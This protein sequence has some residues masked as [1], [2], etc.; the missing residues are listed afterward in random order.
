MRSGIFVSGT[1][2]DVGKS[3]VSAM[4]LYMLRENGINACYFK[5]ALSG[6]LREGDMLIPGDG[7]FVL[8][9][10][11]VKEKYDRIIPHIYEIPVSPHLAGRIE[12]NRVSR[13]EIIRKYNELKEAYDYIL[14]EGA[15]GL[16]VPLNDQG[17]M[18]RDLI[19]DLELDVILVSRAGVGT[20]NHTSL[21]MEYAKDVGINIQGVILNGYS[22][23]NVAHVDN[24]KMIEK[25]NDAKIIMKVP[26]LIGV[27]VENLEFGNLKEMCIKLF[28]EEI[29]K[30]LK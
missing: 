30:E 27:D 10:A 11:G 2:T 17:Y 7:R 9:F 5:A 26:E 1:D 28:S 25:I 16:I 19:N 13:D 23:E 24:A 14:V 20:I 6:A 15:G 4:L 12:G 18:T 3:V 29:L 21:S 22:E 8:E